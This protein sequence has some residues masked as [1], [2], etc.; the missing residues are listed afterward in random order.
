MLPSVWPCDTLTA[1]LCNTADLVP[2]RIVPCFRNQG[3]T[4]HRLVGKTRNGVV[5]R[6][7]S[8]CDYDPPFQED[9]ILG[10]VVS[11]LRDG[12]RIDPSPAW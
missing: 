12:R 5:T 9:E 3:F 11:I 2:D 10:E 6:G 7:D 1:N 8:L 4:A